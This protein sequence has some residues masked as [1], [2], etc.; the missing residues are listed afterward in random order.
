[1]IDPGV[2]HLRVAPHALGA[3]T[4]VFHIDD[5]QVVDVT[6]A[7]RAQARADEAYT[8]AA[9]K[10]DESQVDAKITA[11]ANGKN[12]ITRS[13]SAASG[14]G[15][16]V[17][18]LWVQVDSA[19]DAFRQW[20]WDGSAW[21]PA[22]IKSDML[23]ALDVHK[24]QVTGEAKIDSAVIDKLWVDVLVGKT[25]TYHSLTVATGNLVPN[26]SG[27]L[28]N[29]AS[30]PEFD[31]I[32]GAPPETG[33]QG[34]FRPKSTSDAWRQVAYDQPIPVKP[35]DKYA[36]SIWIHCEDAGS[37]TAIAYDFLD[38]DGVYF[39]RSYALWP[40]GMPAGLSYHESSFTV[41]DGAVALRFQFV[42]N[43]SNGD[44]TVQTIYGFNVTKMV[45]AVLI[46]DGAITTPK[47]TVTEDMSAAIVN[48]MSVD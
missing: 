7:R 42:T 20:Y 16:V 36:T 32:A 30:W 6:E 15:V 44:A 4:D 34:G 9:K 46:E 2:T 27:G 19:G 45:G 39:S 22:Q 38:V 31:Y 29:N 37:D 28:G 43:H 41:P 23:E 25:E 24:L 13:T 3:S 8:E 26:G 1:E 35:G 48:A 12:S 14:K 5:V 11:S 33:A 21:K 47:L 40:K 18:D 17:G 10:L